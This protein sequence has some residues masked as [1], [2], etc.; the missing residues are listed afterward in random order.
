MKVKSAKSWKDSQSFRT[1]TGNKLQRKPLSPT[2][3][4]VADNHR[5]RQLD[6]K[7]NKK[8]IEESRKSDLRLL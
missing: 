5:I 1:H 2:M 6:A 3:Q 8:L 4:L 7:R